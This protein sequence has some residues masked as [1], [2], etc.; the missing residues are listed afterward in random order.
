MDAVERCTH[1]PSACPC[2]CISAKAC[3]L[4]QPKLITKLLTLG[5][6]L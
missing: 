5:I 3:W 6:T 1:M 2:M 4:Q